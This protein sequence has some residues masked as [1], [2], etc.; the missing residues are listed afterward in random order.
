MSS[1]DSYYCSY[2]DYANA[3]S[4]NKSSEN[5]NFKE[6]G[7]IVCPFYIFNTSSKHAPVHVPVKKPYTAVPQKKMDFD[8][9]TRCSGAISIMRVE[10]EER[11]KDAVLRASRQVN[12]MSESEKI[13]VARW[14]KS[15]LPY[16]KSVGKEW[17]PYLSQTVSRK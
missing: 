1:V 3:L 9:H 11:K 16:G 14:M 7:K 13:R 5:H 15:N 12:N 6:D 10:L 2:C 4:E 17:K 8:L